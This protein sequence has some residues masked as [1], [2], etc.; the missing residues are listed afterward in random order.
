MTA[1]TVAGV[2]QIE[3]WSVKPWWSF[4]RNAWLVQ[5]EHQ[6]LARG[7]WIRAWLVTEAE[8]PAKF[9]LLSEALAAIETFLEAPDWTRCR[10]FH[11]V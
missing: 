3:D 7:G 10:E 11:G 5:V 6:I 9:S 2:A 8:I 1:M 4:T